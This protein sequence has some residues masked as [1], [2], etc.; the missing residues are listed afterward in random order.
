[1]N[2][3]KKH[4]AICC[5]FFF[6]C[7]MLA[8]YRLQTIWKK[9]SIILVHNWVGRGMGLFLIWCRSQTDFCIALSFCKR[10]YKAVLMSSQEDP[11]PFWF[12]CAS[13][14]VVLLLWLRFWFYQMFR[15][16]KLA[17]LMLVKLFLWNICFQE[18]NQ[19]D[20]S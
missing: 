9:K 4:Y 5:S 10:V 18:V 12:N 2:L 7:Q 20:C 1:M 15:F 3:F 17:K 13:K 11:R 8:C 16:K 6:F 14:T 19:V